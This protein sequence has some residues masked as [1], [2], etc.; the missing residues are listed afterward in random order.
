M[1]LFRLSD[2]GRLLNGRGSQKTC[3]ANFVIALRVTGVVAT[4]QRVKKT[5]CSPSNWN[6]LKGFFIDSGVDKEIG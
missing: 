4:Q 5:G 1:P 3:L 6:S 2:M